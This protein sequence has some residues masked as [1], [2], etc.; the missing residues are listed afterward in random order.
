MTELKNQNLDMAIF[1]VRAD[2]ADLEEYLADFGI[3]AGNESALELQKKVLKESTI[4]PIAFQNTTIAY[5]PA[6]N[7]VFTTFG[8][9]YID[10]SFIVKT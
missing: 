5:S 2:S 6:L 4:F 9:G 8:N 10:F 3:D 1:P 7:D